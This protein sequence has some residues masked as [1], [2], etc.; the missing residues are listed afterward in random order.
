[1]NEQLSADEERPS[2]VRITVENVGFAVGVGLVFTFLITLLA[3]CAQ[4]FFDVM[5]NRP[6]EFSRIWHVLTT[7][8]YIFLF[9]G[10]II[11]IPVFALLQRT[12]LK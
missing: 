12:R 9:V 10:P 4:V 11:F 3:G 2:T 5:D 1:M 8:P 7:V 6:V